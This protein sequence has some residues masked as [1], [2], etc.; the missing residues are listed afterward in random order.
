MLLFYLPVE[1]RIHI[2]D[3]FLV[4]TVLYKAE[5]LTEAYKMEIIN[6]QM[7]HSILMESLV[8]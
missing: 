4:Q 3:V 6:L 1:A 8:A 2:V 7:R 5:T